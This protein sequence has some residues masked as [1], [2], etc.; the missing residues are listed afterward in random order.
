MCLVNVTHTLRT[1]TVQYHLGGHKCVST[2]KKKKEERKKKKKE[3][4]GREGN[5]QSLIYST[6]VTELLVQVMVRNW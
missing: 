6:V 3:N 2:L 1:H 5:N 4:K